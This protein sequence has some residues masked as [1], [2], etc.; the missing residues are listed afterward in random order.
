[1]ISQAA[2]AAY[3]NIIDAVNVFVEDVHENRETVRSLID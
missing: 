1:M 2:F 3:K